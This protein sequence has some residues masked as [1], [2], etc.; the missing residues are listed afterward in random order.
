MAHQVW[1]S[2]RFICDSSA[3][4]SNG[5]P[6][7]SP[8]WLSLVSSDLCENT[9]AP[10]LDLPPKWRKVDLF[11]YYNMSFYFRAISWFFSIC[12]LHSSL[13]LCSTLWSMAPT[14]LQW[15]VVDFLHQGPWWKNRGKSLHGLMQFELALNAYVRSPHAKHLFDNSSSN[16]NCKWPWF[17]SREW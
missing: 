16:I 6:Q 11:N 4:V 10:T 7:V 2:N 3:Y 1:A 17:I 15:T 9:R 12:S 8:V 13:L 5:F 14:E